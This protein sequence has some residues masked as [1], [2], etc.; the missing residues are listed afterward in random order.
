MKCTTCHRTAI[1]LYRYYGSVL[2]DSEIFCAQCAPADHIEKQLLVPMIED[3]DGSV[4]G[5]TSVPEEAIQR[6]RALPE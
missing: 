5:Y 1:K 6:W 4:W 3:T 2:R